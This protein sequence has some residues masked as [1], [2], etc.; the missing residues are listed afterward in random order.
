M[1]KFED[2]QKESLRFPILNGFSISRLKTRFTRRVKL[3]LANIK[4]F[5]LAVWAVFKLLRI[6][7][8]ILII[9]AVLLRLFAAKG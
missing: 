6:A 9:L 8:L 1:R 5:F 2:C 4:A 7:L 3:F